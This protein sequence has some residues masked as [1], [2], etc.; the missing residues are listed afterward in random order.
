MRIVRWIK[1]MSTALDD[2]P[3]QR[4]DR[5]CAAPRIMTAMV[6]IA[7]YLVRVLAEPTATQHDIIEHMF[8]MVWVINAFDFMLTAYVADHSMRWVNAHTIGLIILIL[9]LIPQF[10]FARMIA[11]LYILHRGMRGWARRHFHLYIVG[12]SVLLLSMGALLVFEAE[13]H[14]PGA[15]IT[16]FPDALWWAVVSVTTMGY[17]AYYPITLTGRLITVA[18]V[19]GGI[20]LIGVITG[21]CT[22]WVIDETSDMHAAKGDAPMTR[23]QAERIERKLDALSARLERLDDGG[24]D[25]PAPPALPERSERPECSERS[26][27]RTR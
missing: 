11:A 12:A 10:G 4:W 6:F 5:L 2:I 21:V 3:L 13:R 7:L 8:D 16:T 26:Q 22:S 1:R 27:R 19:I 17:G 25:R 18:M 14:V 15:S 20:S 9:P 24:I 23:E